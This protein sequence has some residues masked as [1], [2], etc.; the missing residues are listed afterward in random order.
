MIET[1]G[2][3]ITE[4]QLPDIDAALDEMLTGAK[5]SSVLLINSDDGSLIAAR[6]VTEELDTTS[7]AA[8][9]AGAF[10]GHAEQLFA[11]VETDY[12][13]A[14]AGQLERVATAA[15]GQV[16]NRLALGQGQ[17]LLDAVDV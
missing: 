6:G 15:A 11:Q 1:T 2:L 13:V 17:E 8:L 7:L 12:A 14:A 5:A 16:E 3:A 10:A 9:A 4:A